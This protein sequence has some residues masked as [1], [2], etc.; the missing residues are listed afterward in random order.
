MTTRLPHTADP[1]DQ[2]Q[3]DAAWAGR[4]VLVGCLAYALF[5]VYGS[6]VPLNFR[7]MPLAEAWQSFR[8]IPF[9]HLGIGQRADWVANVLLFIPLSFLWL[10]ALAPRRFSPRLA[11]ATAVLLI[12]AALS[13]LIEFVQLFFPPRTVSQNDIYA[14]TLGALIGVLGWWWLGGRLRLWLAAWKAERAATSLAEQALWTYL[15][16]VFV[17]NVL[18]L[19]LTISPVEIYHKWSHG[20]IRLVPFSHLDANLAQALYG[21]GTDAMIWM[22]VPVLWVLAGRRS[23]VHAW[24]LATGAAAMLEVAQLFVWSRITDLTQILTASTGAGLA[25]VG[26]HWVKHPPPVEASGR[27]ITLSPFLWVVIGIAVW[28]ATLLM[29]FWYPFDFHIDR[30]YL[31]TRVPMLFRVPFYNYYYGSEYRAATEVLHKMLFPAPLGALLALGLRRLPRSFPRNLYGV[32]TV[33][34][35]PALPLAI[36]VGKLALP[37]KFP[38]ST[39]WAL[40]TISIVAV[41]AATRWVENRLRGRRRALTPGLVLRR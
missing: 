26:M 8:K 32:L 22:P 16:G 19:D 35:I 36:E 30:A 24:L 13:V 17:Y 34:F 4:V 7:P 20:A 2:R 10:E 5:V 14:E 33:I 11:A 6:L 38:D 18:P 37:N 28:S 21:L 25:A 41:Y 15:A 31:T 40:E 27:G 29:I 1:D 39:N 9:L 12:C 3:R 23:V